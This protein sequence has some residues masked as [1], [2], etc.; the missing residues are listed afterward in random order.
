L[1]YAVWVCRSV[2]KRERG[3]PLKVIAVGDSVG[4]NGETG[5]VAAVP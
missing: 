4:A 1:P 3:T 2:F 5:Q